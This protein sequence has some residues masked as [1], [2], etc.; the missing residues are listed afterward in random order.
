[1]KIV[2]IDNEGVAEELTL[3]K[4]YIAELNLSQEELI[5]RFEGIL[6]VNDKGL[7]GFYKADRFISVQE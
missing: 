7:S 2:C 3:Q 6:L 1:M 5:K 4:T